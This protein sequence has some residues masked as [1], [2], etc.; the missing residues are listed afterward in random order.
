MI[1]RKPSVSKIESASCTSIAQRSRPMPVSM[2]CFGSGVTEP[3]A[4]RSNSMKTRFQ[5][6]M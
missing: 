6:S 1:R 2:F 3:S 5:N 4:P